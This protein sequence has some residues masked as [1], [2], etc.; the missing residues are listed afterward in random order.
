[1]S[2]QIPMEDIRETV[3]LLHAAGAAVATR[4]LTAYDTMHREDAGELGA[5]FYAECVKKL[6]RERGTETVLKQTIAALCSEKE[7]T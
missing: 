5:T 2:G 4:F 3:N 7:N 1:M 6:A